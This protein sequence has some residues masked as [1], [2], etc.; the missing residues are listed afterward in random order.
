MVL[1]RFLHNINSCNTFTKPFWQ[2][3]RRKASASI[4]CFRKASPPPRPPFSGMG[5]DS[6]SNGNYRPF[7]FLS[8]IFFW[9]IKSFEIIK[10]FYVK[11]RFLFTMRLMLSVKIFFFLFLIT[12]TKFIVVAKPFFHLSV[13]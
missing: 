7:S 5:H 10:R 3:W 4:V 9:L 1:S 11:N 8:F 12:V 6:T 13:P 2:H